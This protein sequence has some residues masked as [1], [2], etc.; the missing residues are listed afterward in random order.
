MTC[1]KASQL[2]VGAYLANP[3]ADRWAEF[4]THY[5]GCADCSRTVANWG[6]LEE[7]LRTQGSV[8]QTA[9]IENANLARLAADPGAFSAELRTRIEGHLSGCAICSDKLAALQEFDF[10]ALVDT[11]APAE[12]GIF[13]GAFRSAGEKLRQLLAGSSPDSSE[14]F[15][16]LFPWRQPEVVF[17]SRGGAA[18]ENQAT[19]SSPERGA[20]KGLL[21]IVEGNLAGQVYSVFDGE[22]R[23]GRA[24]D[25]EVWIPSD[26]LA[27]VEATL[28]VS[29][30]RFELSAAQEHRAPRIN[31]EA[32]RTAELRDGDLVELGAQKLR[33]RDIGAGSPT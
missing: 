33:F 21:A 20:S 16:E 32:L 10:E 22:N 30:G 1:N 6:Q 28:T 5:T 14:A 12:V 25:C 17:Q 9:H 29:N 7:A 2:D 27:R 31:G 4:R 15:N 3:G 26:D 19:G 24:R 18:E 11:T 13:E 8:S 23:I